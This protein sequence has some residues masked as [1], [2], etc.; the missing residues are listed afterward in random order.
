MKKNVY[1]DRYYYILYPNIY[2]FLVARS[3]LRKGNPV[4]L[5]KKLV[6]EVGVTRVI[7]GRN[8]IQGVLKDLGKAHSTPNG[9]IVKDAAGFMISG[10][11]ASFLIKDPE[12]LTIL[13]DLYDT[14][15]NEPE[16]KNTTKT[17]GID[18]LKN[19]CIT[20]L[21]ATN[22]EHFQDA[23]PTNAIGGGFI[24]RT[25]IVFEGVRR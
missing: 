3:G 2:V 18:T 1:L 21:G 16:W 10:E 11:L 20:L 23:V 19:P 8:S 12:A 22:E 14:H 6:Q 7:S 15:V 24:G 5:A 13:T 17:Q 9:T 25:S 4:N